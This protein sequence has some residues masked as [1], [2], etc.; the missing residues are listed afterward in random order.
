MQHLVDGDFASNNGGWQWSASTGTD[1]APYFRVFNPSAQSR[2]FDLQGGFIRRFLPELRDVPTALL[3]DPAALAERRPAGIDYP[4]PICD[5]ALAR[6]RA[7]ETF[8]R[9]LKRPGRSVGRNA[10]R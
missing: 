7:I 4:P 1:A 5:H 2:R 9:V 8:E 6:Q 3:H 10:A